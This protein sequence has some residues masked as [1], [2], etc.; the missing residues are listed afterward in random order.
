MKKNNILPFPTPMGD[1]KEEAD[2]F[3]QR[4][5]YGKWRKE[6]ANDMHCPVCQLTY[7]Q[8]NETGKVQ[9]S[10]CYDAFEKEI[11]TLIERMQGSAIYEGKRPKRKGGLLHSYGGNDHE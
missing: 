11:R 9:C 5:M 2:L 1:T 6:K 7:E 3:L 4:I 10:A 8:L